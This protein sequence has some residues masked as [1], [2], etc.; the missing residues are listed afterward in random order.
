MDSDN[1]NELI[2]QN[3]NNLHRLALTLTKSNY[4]ADDLTNETCIRIIEKQKL[5]DPDTKFFSW[6]ATVMKNIF[7]NDI[8]RNNLVTWEDIYDDYTQVDDNNDS[9]YS[10]S[11][12][13]LADHE[14]IYLNIDLNIIENYLPEY[15]KP[16]F[17]LR[18]LGFDYN[19]IAE[20]LNIPVGTV[21]SRLH[22]IKDIARNL[23]DH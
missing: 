21:K 2:K 7:L 10:D 14:S 8:K 17:N 11:N 23:L 3:Y 15:L 9:N 18:K 6:A 5:W 19:E 1:F 12:S 22:K 13:F 16:V 4:Y 20:N